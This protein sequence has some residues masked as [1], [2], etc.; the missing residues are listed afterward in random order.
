[1]PDKTVVE[2]L[3]SKTSKYEIL[4][5]SGTFSTKFYLYKDGRPHRG[6]FSSLRDAVEAAR[7]EGAS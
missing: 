6:Y 3:Y 7:E 4:K 2:T 1:M 5:D